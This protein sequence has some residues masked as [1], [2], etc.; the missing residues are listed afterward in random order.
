MPEHCSRQP[1]SLKLRR[2]DFAFCRRRYS[3]QMISS[4]EVDA[5]PR[6]VRP[7]ARLLHF[8]PAAA[9]EHAPASAVVLFRALTPSY[10]YTLKHFTCAIVIYF[11]TLVY[12]F[13][14][15]ARNLCPKTSSVFSTP[16]RRDGLALCY[17]IA[18]R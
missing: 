3:G 14:A 15:D 7:T 8:A 18:R 17:D 9:G 10:I 11:S 2:S 5:L 4:R 6:E 13:T 1:H 12:A 16:T